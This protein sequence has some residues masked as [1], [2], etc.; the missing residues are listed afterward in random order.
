MFYN[1]TYNV[2]CN[3]KQEL[4]WIYLWS[5]LQLDIWR[6]LYVLIKVLRKSD[7]EFLV[8]A[9]SQIGSQVY[10]DVH[11]SSFLRSVDSSIFNCF[12]QL[13][14]KSPTIPFLG[15]WKKEREKLIKFNNICDKNMLHYKDVLPYQHTYMGIEGRLQDVFI[16]VFGPL[17]SLLKVFFK[18]VV[19]LRHFICDWLN[20][21]G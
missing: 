14:M 13:L 8:N 1:T 19:N 18:S 16:W 11:F 7:S 10:V 15:K 3:W 6:G 20:L 2:W 9:V 4:Q 5:M 21:K 12:F 17:N